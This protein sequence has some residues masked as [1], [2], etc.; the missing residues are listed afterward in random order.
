[1]NERKTVH[2]EA[3]EET[4]LSETE[5]RRPSIEEL[6]ERPHAHLRKT[7]LYQLGH[8]RRQADAIFKALDLV[9]VPGYSKP[10]ILVGDYLGLIKRSTYGNDVVHPTRRG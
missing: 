9:Y 7:D 8:T 3:A 5:S 1:V 10:T 4:E 6:L 2:A